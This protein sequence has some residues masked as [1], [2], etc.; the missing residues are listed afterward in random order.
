MSQQVQATIVESSR[1]QSRTTTRLQGFWLR[2]ARV[3]WVLLGL[4][5]LAFLLT[6]LP[7]YQLRIVSGL[8]GHG[9]VS[10]PSMGYVYL[11]AINA[12]TSLASS[13]LSLYLALL[14][15]R[16]KFEN[17]AVA[18]V[19]FYLLLYGI[20]MTGP[21]DSW[22]LYWFGKNQFAIPAQTLIMATPTAALLVLFPNGRFV[23]KWSR[24]ILIASLPWNLF[25]ILFPAFPYREDQIVGLLILAF[26]WVGLLGLGIYTQI[27]R[28]TRV[29]TIEE[30]QQTKWV[31]YGFGLWLG[32]ILISTY[33]YI[34][35]TSLPPDAPQPWW[36][37]VTE[38]TWWLSLNILPVTLMIAITRSRLWNIDIVINRTLVYVILTIATMALYILVVGTLGN[39]LRGGDSTFIAFL[40][41]GLIAVIFHPLRERL[42][43]WVNRL[44][45]GDRDDPYAVLTSLGKQLENSARIDTTLPAI[46]RTIAKTLKLPYVG[47]SL[48]N[49]DDEGLTAAY[50]QLPTYPPEEY[51]LLN[52]GESIGTLILAQRSE[53]ES[54]TRAEKRLLADL[55]RQVGIAAHNVRLTADL[56]RSRQRIVTAREEE[57]RRLRRDLHD[58]L[59]PQLA[60]QTLTLNAIEKLIDRDPENAKELIHGLG[61]QSQEA[62][63]SIRQLIYELRPPTLDELGLVE[64]LKEGSA[65]YRSTVRIEI[66]GPQALPPLPAAVE[67]AAYHIVQEAIVNIIRHSQASA[68]QVRVEIINNNLH[69]VIKDNGRGLPV[70]L[71]AGVGLHSMRERVNELNGQI[72][73]DSSPGEGTRVYVQ[74]PL[75]KEGQ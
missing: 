55:A 42:Q 23:P 64:A 48:E 51:P 29:S 69:I 4:V 19:S 8:P 56:Q 49:E 41:T 17:P 66:D 34:Y 18:A 7:G 9:P 21:L 75:P 50:G 44:M 31:L 12:I 58:G 14:L 39:V 1:E 35:I 61:A 52:Q 57:R 62:I 59:G 11:Q 37:P 25:A 65:N 68:C 28:Y 22:G 20:V 15:F 54:F 60:S 24:W 67:V 32:Y 26:F 53:S 30:R 71:K 72:E 47:I 74:L 2:L 46:A 43:S 36:S 16:R 10:D 6:S 40:T 13:L 73:F 45:Y 38:F 3:G 33:P 27:Y 70:D 63:T 5:S